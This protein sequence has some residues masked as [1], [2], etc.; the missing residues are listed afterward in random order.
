MR[1]RIYG[2]QFVGVSGF[3][4]NEGNLMKVALKTFL[5]AVPQRAQTRWLP[6]RTTLGGAAR[7]GWALTKGVSWRGWLGGLATVGQH[8]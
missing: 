8:P 1:Y 2:C 7:R 6:L 3:T 4:N 5:K